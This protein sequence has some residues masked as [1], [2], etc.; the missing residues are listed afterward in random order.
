MALFGC[1]LRGHR[2]VGYG[3][4]QRGVHLICSRCGESKIIDDSTPS[5]SGVD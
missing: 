1:W 5:S 2:Y 3:L 4:V